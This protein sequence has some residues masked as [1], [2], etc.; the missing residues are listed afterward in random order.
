MLWAGI[1]LTLILIVLIVYYLLSDPLKAKT[2]SLVFVAHTFGGRAAAIGL[3]IINEM[4]F[5]PTLLY[6]FFLE[7]QIT[8]V[9]YGLFVLSITNYIKVEW[10]HR[11]SNQMMC[12]A[13]R[14]R[15]KIQ[16]YGWA[17]LFIFV[18]LPLPGTGPLMGSFLGYL[19]KVGIWRNF[20]AVLLGTLTAIILWIVC[21]DFLEQHLHM[22]QY[23]FGAIIIFV[24]FS[25]F[26]TIKSWFAKKN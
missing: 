18:M 20:S 17:G 1:F 24:V 19:L 7:T 16:K 9:I 8:C 25:H 2:L 6:N 10:V 5:F 13:D 3:C 14:N 22:L 23:I 11:I 4:K 15:E 21:F 26:N 12:N